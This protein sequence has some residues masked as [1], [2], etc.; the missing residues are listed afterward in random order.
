MINYA[1]YDLVGNK[2]G[3]NGF[4]YELNVGIRSHL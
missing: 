4:K 1:K 2:V 3:Y